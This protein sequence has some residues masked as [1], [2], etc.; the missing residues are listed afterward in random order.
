M[1]AACAA[2]DRLVLTHDFSC[3]FR[4]SLFAWGC[5][6]VCPGVC[7][8]A[9]GVFG[10]PLPYTG[11][12]SDRGRPRLSSDGLGCGGDDLRTEDSSSDN[13]GT[14]PGGPRENRGEPRQSSD[15]PFSPRTGPKSGPDRGTEGGASDIRG[16]SLR[17]SRPGTERGLKRSGSGRCLR[18]GRQGQT[19]PRD[20]PAWV[21]PARVTMPKRALSNLRLE[22]QSESYAQS[23]LVRLQGPLLVENFLRQF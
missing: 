12:R 21:H 7:I 3:A 5:E 17:C 11:N 6:D 9:V 4:V 8:L 14:A 19:E 20:P 2:H 13:R 10:G 22:D 1:C 23:R 18:V 16:I 15:A